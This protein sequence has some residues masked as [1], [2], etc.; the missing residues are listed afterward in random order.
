MR[1]LPEWP[2]HRRGR[3]RRARPRDTAGRHRG[4]SPGDARG[5]GL[6]TGCEL[7]RGCLGKVSR[8]RMGPPMNHILSRLESWSAKSKICR[9]FHLTA[10]EMIRRREQSKVFQSTLLL[11][12]LS[13]LLAL[14]YSGIDLP[15]EFLDVEGHS[16]A[17]L[18]I[19]YIAILALSVGELVFQ[20]RVPHMIRRYENKLEYIK[21]EV[22]VLK[23]PAAFRAVASLIDRRL[24][25]H[26]AILNLTEP[27]VATELRS[28]LDRPKQLHLDS[29][30]LSGNDISQLMVLHW[31]MMNMCL[32]FERVAI[33]YLFRL[34]VFLFSLATALSIVPSLYY[35]FAMLFGALWH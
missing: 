10:W 7:L 27:R 29:E 28:E 18:A 8:H 19:F 1:R 5:G 31:D 15:L 26:G 3:G 4:L 6:K 25:E 32:P 17:R 14:I 16:S 30:E 2:A 23:F 20:L 34:G 24:D 13:T 21:S 22:E 33:F 11:P 12:V 9:R 35:A